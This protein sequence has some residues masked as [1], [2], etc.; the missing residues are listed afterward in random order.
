MI[1]NTEVQPKDLTHRQIQ[2]A[3]GSL[4][5]AAVADALGAPFEFKP[6]GKYKEHFPNRVLGGIG[7]M[8]GGGG[9]KWAPAEFTD[10]TQMALAMAEAFIANNGEYDA[11]S[12]WEHFVSWAATA[13]DIGNTTYQSLSHPNYL[14]AAESTHK[15]LGRSGSNGGVMRTAPLGLLAIR[16]GRAKAVDI[17]R[18]QARLTHFDDVASWCSAIVTEI[19]RAC[20]L[21]ASFPEA[22]KSATE[23]L[24][25]E[26]HKVIEPVLTK[27]WSEDEL[28]LQDNGGA[29]ECL[30][31]AVW[32]IK[33]SHSYEDAVVSAV[34][35][36]GDADTVAAVCG[37]MAG[38]LYGIQCIPARWATYVN[39]TVR[40]SSGEV[41]EYLLHDL[42]RTAHQLLGT[43]SRPMTDPE[44]VISALSVHDAGLYA[45]N[46]MG[47]QQANPELAIISLCRME[48]SLNHVA[49]RREFYIIDEWGGGHNPNLQNVVE[50]AVDA[51]DAFLREGREVLVH[52]HGGRS[53][54]G[55]IL[56]AWYM[57]HHGVSNDEAHDWLTEQWPHYVTWNEDFTNF[58]EFVWQNE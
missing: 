22:L 55:F 37:G 17:A 11:K 13:K 45:S 10:D 51:I 23:I 15:A 48:G 1:S 46:L 44:P 29:L 18:Q 6:A 8:I 33:T 7:E 31:Q 56:K 38:A 12:V 26:I 40:Q 47:A 42:V 19:I 5:G 21:G 3:I 49:R 54:T 25:T 58:L 32:A 27:A 28:I 57:R 16:W 43:S 36:G 50:D 20:I 39:G 41:R 4:V 30:L 34:N 24:P 35:L 14:E 2:A 53:R 52:C 9:F